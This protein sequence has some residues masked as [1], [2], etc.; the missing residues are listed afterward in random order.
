MASPEHLTSASSSDSDSIINQR[1]DFLSAIAWTALGI[2]IL[3][4]S[5]MMD[6]LEDQDINPYTIPGLLPGLLGIVM[7]ILGALLALRS[8]S[9][10]V[11]T[12]TPAT[13]HSTDRAGYARLLLV[14]GLCL[15]FGVVLI[16]HGL[17]FWLAGAIFVT[18]SILL[19]QLH[20]RNSLGGKMS[21]RSV[22]AA[23]AIGVGAGLAIT[24]VFQHLFL[25]HLP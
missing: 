14:L 11:L 22:V 4:A 16:G 12:S 9:P 8:W 5:V 19:L 21:A 2:A 3:I 6:R 13:D 10:G 7:T 17:P 20:Q 24:F 25:V 23:A 15:I 18:A 1:T